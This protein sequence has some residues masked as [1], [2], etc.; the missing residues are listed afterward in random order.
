MEH[1]LHACVHTN[2]QARQLCRMLKQHTSDAASTWG[3]GEAATAGPA[4]GAA[5][6][7]APGAAAAANGAAGAGPGPQQPLQAAS[8]T[9][10]PAPLSKAGAG[11]VGL[12]ALPKE[13]KE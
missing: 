1:N 11:K 4:E 2:V 8:G 13:K 6:G 3:T 7:A 5:A 12:D 10:T 9:S